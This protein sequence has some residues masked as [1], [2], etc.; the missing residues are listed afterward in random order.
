[1]GVQG[2]LIL[3]GIVVLIIGLRI[4]AAY[5]SRVK[6][7]NCK[8]RNCVETDREETSRQQ[9]MFEEEEVIKHVDNKRGSFGGVATSRAQLTA[10]FGK[11]DSITIRKYKVPG[12]RVHYEVTYKCN[13]CGKNFTE[14][15]HVDIKAPTV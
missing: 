10:Q 4:L 11:P 1:M 8:K 14:T 2:W 12:E 15:T 3:I 7:P 5:F 9:V 13:D 6:C